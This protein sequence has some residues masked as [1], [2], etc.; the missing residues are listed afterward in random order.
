MITPK[1]YKN[2]IEKGIISPNLLGEAIYSI[3]KRAKNHRDRARRT[4]KPEWKASAHRK[5]DEFYAMKDNILKFAKPDCIHKVTRYNS[6][7][8]VSFD[9]YFLFYVLGN[10]S[11]HS[12]ISNEEAVKSSLELIELDGLETEGKEPKELL[13]VPFVRKIILALGNGAI[14]A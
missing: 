8:G 14:I 5:K 1:T 2:E 12:P 9:E 7:T 4:R 13:S 6:Y 3:N 11:F 10:F